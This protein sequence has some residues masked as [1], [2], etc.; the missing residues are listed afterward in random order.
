MWDAINNLDRPYKRGTPGVT[1]NLD[2][3][4]LSEAKL[5]DIGFPRRNPQD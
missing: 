1:T 3:N 5:E 4:G 2:P